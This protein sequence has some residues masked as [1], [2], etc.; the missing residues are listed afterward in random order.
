MSFH[1]PIS[2]LLT[3]IR[4]AREAEH[5]FVDVYLNKMGLNVV[6]VLKENGF[7]E[8]YLVDEKKR[9]MR[10]FFRFGGKREVTIQGLKRVSSPGLRRYVGYKDIPYVLSGMGIAI[11]ST[12]QGVLDGEA[13]RKLK[14]GGEL[15]CLVW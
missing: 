5:R 4:N 7:V 14:V 2:D 10:I 12:P 3:R 1:D 8:N 9:K 13:A 15:L 6:K 11:L